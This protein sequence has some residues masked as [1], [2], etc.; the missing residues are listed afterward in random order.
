MQ[1]IN[2]YIKFICYG[3][4]LLM[5]IYLNENTLI[6]IFFLSSIISYY[7]AILFIIFIGKAIHKKE[8]SKIKKMDFPCPFIFLL[9]I[10]TTIVITL[11]SLNKDYYQ[12][13]KTFVLVYFIITVFFVS[14]FT[15]K[16]K[17]KQ[18][19][20]NNSIDLYPECVNLNMAL[21]NHIK[22]LPTV[23]HYNID[24]LN[25]TFYKY[26]DYI[27]SYYLNALKSE[28]DNNDTT[29][30]SII[31]LLI[32]AVLGKMF[33]STD[34]VV[35]NSPT[36]ISY[37]QMVLI[38]SC[39]YMATFYILFLIDGDSIEKKKFKILTYYQNYKIHI[40]NEFNDTGLNI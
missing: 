26:P 24:I 7:F 15:F 33:D 5:N 10:S 4:D 34:T 18:N 2:A 14:G 12:L 16:K 30:T 25:K 31:F 8:L 13:G 11:I 9:I 38:F 40:S 19:R 32:G 17:Y 28:N 20:I 29:I 37:I 23:N 3:G 6:I 21:N 36:L 35:Q 27:M 22:N 39:I 1:T